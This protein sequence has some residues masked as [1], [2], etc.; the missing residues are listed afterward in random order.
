LVDARV[1][2]TSNLEVYVGK[3]THDPYQVSN[4]PDDVV[5]RLCEPILDTGRNVTIDNWFTSYDL[6]IRMLTNHRL[7]IVGTMKKIYTRDTSQLSQH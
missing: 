5:E 6:A 1:F 7:T 4:S 2:Y 3:Q